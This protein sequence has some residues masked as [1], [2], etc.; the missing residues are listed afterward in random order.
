MIL[1]HSTLVPRPFLSTDDIYEV[2][3][4]FHRTIRPR[5]MDLGGCLNSAGSL[6]FPDQSH[7]LPQKSCV[8]TTTLAADLSKAGILVPDT[9]TNANFPLGELTAGV[10]CA[11]NYKP[12]DKPA[13]LNC[14][15][16]TFE[17]L[18]G[19]MKMTVRGR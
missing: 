7:A 16:P 8:M 4:R 12:V 6:S 19:C 9:A 1:L 15:P 5:L 3:S 11:P 13:A 10:D 14:E 17:V 18:H 2:V